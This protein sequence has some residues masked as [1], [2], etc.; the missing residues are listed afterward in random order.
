MRCREDRTKPVSTHVHFLLLSFPLLSFLPPPSLRTEPREQRPN[1][2]ADGDGLPAK[3]TATFTFSLN[4]QHYTLLPK[5]IAR[6]HGH[7]L[8][9][10]S[11]LAGPA[12]PQAANLPRAQLS[13]I[14]APWTCLAY[15]M[16]GRCTTETL[17]AIVR[18]V[19]PLMAN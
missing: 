6:R 16:L 13:P 3:Q 19:G 17:P 1:M 4:F 12:R 15:N 11:W 14:G 7:G 18:Y 9:W 10:P 8:A 2:P 5:Y